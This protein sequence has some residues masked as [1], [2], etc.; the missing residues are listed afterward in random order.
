MPGFRESDWTDR[1]HPAVAGAV[2]TFLDG[3][4]NLAA[5]NVPGV[6]TDIIPPHLPTSGGE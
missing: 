3:T 4:Y 1:H 6:Y 5:L 2:P